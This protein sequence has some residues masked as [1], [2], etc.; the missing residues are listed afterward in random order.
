MKVMNK[1]REPKYFLGMDI[2]AW[3]SRD[4]NAITVCKMELPDEVV[5]LHSHTFQTQHLKPEEVKAK[6]EYIMAEY[7]MMYSNLTIIK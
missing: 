7:Y 1:I 5:V 6:W 4:Y 3:N 2:A